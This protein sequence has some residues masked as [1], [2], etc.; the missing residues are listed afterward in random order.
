M[1]RVL[2]MIVLETKRKVKVQVLDVK[3]LA[4]GM[5]NSASILAELGHMPCE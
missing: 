1:V 5:G 2:V 3:R 4:T